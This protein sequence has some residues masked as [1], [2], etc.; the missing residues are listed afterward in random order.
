ML[1]WSLRTSGIVAKGDLL[2][3]LVRICGCIRNEVVASL[4]TKTKQDR[5]KS[6]YISKRDSF[7]QEKQFLTIYITYL[8]SWMPVRISELMLLSLVTS[9]EVRD[10]QWLNVK[11]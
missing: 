9:L 5:T 8:D 11:L 6:L 2:G 3:L 4:G 1:E 10:N 7:G